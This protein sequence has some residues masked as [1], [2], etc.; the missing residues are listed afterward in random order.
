MKRSG[1]LTLGL[2]L[3]LG[4]CGLFVDPLELAENSSEGTGG[5]ATSPGNHLDVE[6]E[7]KGV[8]GSPGN[9]GCTENCEMGGRGGAE[10][11]EAS[12]ECASEC[13]CDGDGYESIACGGDDCDDQDARVHPGQTEYFAEPSENPEVGF[14]YDCSGT[15][16]RD[17]NHKKVSCGVL[18]L[19]LCKDNE[20]F[21]NDPPP[22]GE[23]GAWG[24][25]VPDA[26]NLTCSYLASEPVVAR[27]R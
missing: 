12:D 4:A 5:V 15:L 21:K 18:D 22:C 19:L 20:G 13:D 11:P 7:D 1:V 24:R 2:S 17:P 10:S 27:C 3:T 25:C 16:E 14:D 6:D 26:L 9:D 23:S 8:G